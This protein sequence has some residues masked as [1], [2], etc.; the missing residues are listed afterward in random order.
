MRDWLMQL[1]SAVYKERLLLQRDPHALMLLFAMPAAFILIMSLAL[2]NQFGAASSSLLQGVAVDADQTDTSGHLIDRLGQQLDLQLLT[3]DMDPGQ[4]EAGLSRDGP[5]FLLRL[6]DG[7]GDAVEAGELAPATHLQ[8]TLAPDIDAI[9]ERLLMGA[10]RE[11]LARIQLEALFADRPAIRAELDIEPDV[12]LQ[13]QY[14]HANSSR[15][16]SAVQQSVP[17]WLVFAVFFIVIPLS[18]TMI[19]ERELGMEKRLRTTP[20]GA[21][22]ALLGK[23]LPYFVV[24][25]VQ[26]VTMLLIG[27]YLVPAF[28]GEALSLAGVPTGGLVLMALSLSLAALGYGLLIAVFCR[29]TEQTTMLGGAGNIILAAIGGI[30]VPKFVMPDGLQTLSLV[31]PMSW[32]LDG[33]LVALLHG[34][35][36][37][38]VLPYSA[39]LAGFGIMALLLART[40]QRRRSY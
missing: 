36:A 10:L 39:A 21:G 25:Q 29:T 27:I 18:N 28:G 16:P 31:S 35:G 26:V 20:Q 12:G 22:V 32:G 37:L 17:A 6:G 14:L 8:L 9:R 2:Q 24:N 15:R 4:L 34:G 38:A 40:L 19:R 11:S 7:F 1:R 13:V 5:V 30:M 3:A 23:L 33:L